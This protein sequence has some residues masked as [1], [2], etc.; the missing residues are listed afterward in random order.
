MSL[1]QPVTGQAFRLTHPNMEFLLFYAETTELANNWLE[2]LEIACDPTKMTLENLVP[3]R[4]SD[5]DSPISERS[6]TLSF[7]AN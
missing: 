2:K 5:D 7:M 3:S 1:P 4:E 6:V